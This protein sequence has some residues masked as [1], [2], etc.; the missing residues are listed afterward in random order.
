[1]PRTAWPLLGLLLL[2]A[3]ADPGELE[4]AVYAGQV[5]PTYEQS[6]TYDPG[7]LPFSIPGVSVEQQGAFRLD[8][9]GALALS[10]GATWFFSRHAGLEA[11]VDTA[12]VSVPAT[13]ARYRIRLDLPAPLPD[14]TRDVDLGE[15]ELDLERL[16]PVS[17]NLRGRVGRMPRV[18][19]SAGLT[20][21][22]ALRVAAR[23]SVGIPDVDARGRD[24]RVLEGAVLA[25]IEDESGHRLGVNAGI[26]LQVPLGTRVSLAADVRYFRFGTS[27][28]R[29]F[30]PR[31]DGLPQA[32][33]ERLQ[34]QIE[35]SLDPI[36]FTPS[37]FHASAGLSV[38]F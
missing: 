10:G 8:A 6:F 17:L 9:R 36:R 27:T 16:L 11:R 24:L 38:A 5:V 32:V 19:A 30:G 23:A 14:L 22:P 13:G 4:L 26:G 37:V 1:M 28:L 20:Y 12:D 21:L 29:W 33:R 31:V 35:A 3:S 25:G 15:G 7:P 2:P 34:Q 18:S